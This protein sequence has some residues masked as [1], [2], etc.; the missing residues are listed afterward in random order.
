MKIIIIFILSL[1]I[2]NVNGQ[3]KEGVAIYNSQLYMSLN[4]DSIDDKDVKS[5]LSKILNQTNNSEELE[6]ELKFSKEKSMFTYL[7]KLDNE[8]NSNLNINLISAKNLGQIYTNIKSDE[9]VTYSK[10]FDKQFLIVE[11]LSSQKWKLINESKLIG[12]YKC[13]K[14]TT[15]KELYRRNGNRMIV[16]TAWYT[17]EIP[18]SF[19]PLGYGNLPGLIVELNEGNSFHYFLKSINY[20][21]IPI[22]IKPSKGKIVSIKEF[23]D[24][25]TEIYLK[26]IKI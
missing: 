24:E 1:T 23:N 3:N 13:Y 12:K 14:A 9:K 17:P 25:M 5:N 19:G 7:Q 11:N 26:K 8:S 20:K 16:V 10:V 6:F 15:Q 2:F 4:T 22:I 21:K 18:L